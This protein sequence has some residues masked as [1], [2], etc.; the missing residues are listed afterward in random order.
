MTRKS[1][2]LALLLVCGLGVGTAT[3]LSLA[4]FSDNLVFFVTPSDLAKEN[5][6]TRSVRLGGLVE[7]GTLRRSSAGDPTAHFRITD[8][9]AS[10]PVTYR[11]LLP[12]LFR[13]GQGVVAMGAM[14]PDGTFKAS[15]VLA[16]H[17]ENYMPKEVAD[18][19]KKSGMW[20]P[21]EG[22]PPPPS[23]WSKAGSAKAGG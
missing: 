5:P 15:E 2:R 1:R 4:A 13:E 12:D 8:G 7:A 9:S 14:Q 10:V 19:L 16:K 23:A 6:G 3:A 18:A 17:D 21:A 20:N 11:G 22:A